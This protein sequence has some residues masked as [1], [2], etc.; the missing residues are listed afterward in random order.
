[1]TEN[2]TNFFNSD[3]FKQ[4][5]ASSAEGWEPEPIPIT[6]IG[7]TAVYAKELANSKYFYAVQGAT[8]PPAKIQIAKRELLARARHILKPYH[9]GKCD[10]F[11]KTQQRDR[12]LCLKYLTNM[13][14]AI[15]MADEW[16]DLTTQV[17]ISLDCVVPKVVLIPATVG[18]AASGVAYMVTRPVIKSTAVRLVSSVAIGSVAGYYTYRQMN[19]N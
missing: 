1:M 3:F 10:G 8:E 5:Q 17:G 19:K 9:H 2:E 16:T 14:L 13:F 15:D 4:M 11:T 6:R 18:V 7:K 12:A